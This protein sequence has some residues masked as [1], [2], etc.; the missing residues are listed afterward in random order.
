LS[1]ARPRLSVA[2]AT[3]E[4][5][6]YVRDL[7]T[8]IRSDVEAAG[9]EIVIADG[10]EHPAP[11]ADELG[12]AV[13]WI[14]SEGGTVF[15]LFA[16]AIQAARGQVVALTE[17]HTIPRAGWIPAVIRAHEEHPEAAAIGGAIENGST[18]GLI[19]WASYFTTQ[20]PHMAPLGNQV[21]PMTTNEANVSYKGDVL[22]NVDPDEG[23]GFMAILYNRRLAE[24]GRILRVDDRI[25]VDHFETIGFR[26][27]TSIHFHNGRTIS[28]FR[29]ER[30]MNPEDWIRVAT[31]MM[32]PAW[33]T[34][35]VMRAG[36]A[37]GRLRRELIAAAPFALWLEYVQAVGH[38]YGYVAGPG[39]SPDHLR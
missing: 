4:G 2:I 14:K 36:W 21:V 28:G 8:S 12:P 30:G 38:L 23:L 17:D 39:G 32:L 33:R 6:P 20:G 9:A 31:S 34:L 26:W 15:K 22:A 37:K 27:T 19:E 35:R 3:G 13:R 16:V 24:Q 10:S 11:N 5:W 7:L 18:F 1:D 29:R 25:V